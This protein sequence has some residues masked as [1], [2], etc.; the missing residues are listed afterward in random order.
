MVAFL[1]FTLYPVL[2]T[3]YIGFT[4]KQ[5]LISEANFLVDDPFKNF[6]EVLFESTLFR[7]ALK[8]TVA[9]WI[10]NFIP[11]MGLALLLTAWFTDNRLRIK[12]K[13]FFKV[14]FYLPNIITMASVAILFRAFFGYPMGPVNDIVTKIKGPGSEIYFLIKKTTTRNIVSFIQFWMWYGYTMV[15]LVSGVLGID[16]SIFE[17]AEIDGANRLQTFFKITIPSIR[18]IL[19]FTLVTS[20]IGGLNMF[21]IPMLLANGGPDNATLTTNLYIYN[22][23]FSGSYKYNTAAAASMIMFTIIVVCSAILFYCMRDKDEAELKKLRKLER[24]EQRKAMAG[25]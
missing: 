20:L 21:D 7:L 25:A 2:Y 10:V 23:A 12:C 3:C 14:I 19:L 16:P 17:A 4:T 24:K 11:Q 15:Q 9:I 22:Q 1:I 6:R 8:N 13:G 5:G 18:T